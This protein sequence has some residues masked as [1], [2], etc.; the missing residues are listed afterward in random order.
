[1][2]RTLIY[3]LCFAMFFGCAA[4]QVTEVNIQCLEETKSL[5]VNQLENDMHPI[6]WAY[7]DEVLHDPESF[8]L[9]RFE[10][11]ITNLRRQ[12]PAKERKYLFGSLETIY[13]NITVPVYEVNM[14]YRVRVP[15]GGIMLKEMQFHLL[16]TKEI[17]LPNG[18]L[19]SL[20][21]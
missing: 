7:L 14:R 2:K 19:V 5:F 21:E 1:M 13:K 11:Q 8:R 17:Y 9:Q 4:K 10:Y 3:F 16:E 15:A 18:N 20:I 12:M 6:I